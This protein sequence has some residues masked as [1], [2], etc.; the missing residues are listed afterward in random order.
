MNNQ[1]PR[2]SRNG[3]PPTTSYWIGQSRAGLAEKIAERRPQ[4]QTPLVSDI[5]KDPVLE[6]TAELKRKA[7][8]LGLPVTRVVCC[9]FLLGMPLVASAQ[10]PDK[11]APWWAT[12]LAVAGPM[13]DGLSTHYAI[14]QSGPN[15]RIA[16]GNGFYSH[17]F[18]SNVTRNEILAFK[19][20]Q[21]ALSGLIIHY[22]GKE[23]RKRA[24][25]SAVIMAAIHATATT[26]NLRA[27]RQARRLNGGA[28]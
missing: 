8:R 6:A 20:G 15:A 16:E 4:Q 17:L 1:K 10:T 19:V 28:R 18:G 26:M 21:A 24:I 2:M 5:T 14:G 27:A 12:T 9:L 25:A 23:D 11:G 22:A 3:V 13:A 7:W